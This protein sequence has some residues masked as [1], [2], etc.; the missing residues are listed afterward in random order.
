MTKGVQQRRGN[1]AQHAS[2]NGQQGEITVNTDRWTVVVQDGSTNGGY[3]HVNLDSTQR[4]S[5]KDIVATNLTV[6]GVST[7]SSDIDV[8]GHTEL[9][10]VNI[11]GVTTFTS[12]LDINASVEISNNLNVTGIAT[13]G[14]ALSFADDIYTRFGDDA[15]LR[16]GHEGFLGQGRIAASGQLRIGTG[17]NIWIQDD[18]FTVTSAVFQPDAGIELYA[19]G[20]KKI[21]T[22][23]AGVTVGAGLTIYTPSL[24]VGAGTT[25][26]PPIK[27]TPG[28]LLTNPQEGAIEYDTRVIYA[29]PA[30]ARAIV[31]AQYYYRNGTSITLANS[32]ANQN[33]LDLALTIPQTGT[34][35]FEGFFAMGTTGTTSH[36]ERTAITGTASFTRVYYYVQRS[37][38]TTGAYAVGAQF[39]E[40]TSTTSITAAITS[41]QNAVYQIKGTFDVT[42]VGTFIPTIGFSAAPGGTTT[43]RAGAYLKVHAI[44]A[45]G[46]D[47][48]VGSWA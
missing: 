17:S 29:S 38:E 31:P 40:N 37:I 22:I 34:Y 13:V 39:I 23:G 44:G 6:S 42:A 21:E 48:I 45:A 28:V 5:N 19:Y 24:D 10:N 7:F 14:T 4:I 30:G 9:D 36:I 46:A 47:I 11:S 32:T 16:I 2:F 26:T 25:L 15:D 43:I 41:A 27:L 20:Q 3:E 33:W 1:T 35:E 12:D 8:D 18:S